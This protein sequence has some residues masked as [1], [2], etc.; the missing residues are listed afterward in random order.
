[1][2]PRHSWVLMIA[3]ASIAAVALALALAITGGITAANFLA[4]AAT[5]ATAVSAA[6]ALTALIQA[7]AAYKEM[8]DGDRPRGPRSFRG[9][10]WAVLQRG[11]A[12]PEGCGRA[13]GAGWRVMRAAARLMPP[14][15]GRLWLGEAESFLAEA[16]AELARSAV[17]SFLV[18]APQVIAIAWTAALFRWAQLAARKVTAK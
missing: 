4:A 14:A 16:P 2:N 10:F 8:P 11:A 9:L 7:R 15:A 13:A 1:V 5:A 3:G 12:G 17:R 6:A 18:T